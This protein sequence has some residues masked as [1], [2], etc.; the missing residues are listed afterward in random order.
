[1]SAETIAGIAAILG[2]ANLAPMAYQLAQGT[3]KVPEIPK[4]GVDPAEAARASAQAAALKQ[5]RGR[6][7]TLIAGSQLSQTLGS[8]PSGSKQLLGL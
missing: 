5:R 2:G 8:A 6:G 3:P 7:A 1:M 4:P